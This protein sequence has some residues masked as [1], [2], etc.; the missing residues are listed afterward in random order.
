MTVLLDVIEADMGELSAIIV[1][2]GFSSG[3]KNVFALDPWPLFSNHVSVFHLSFQCP[4]YNF[5]W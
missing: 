3:L 5:S 1:F 2:F 4:F